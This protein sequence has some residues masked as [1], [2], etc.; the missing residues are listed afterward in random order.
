MKNFLLVCLTLAIQPLA[1]TMDPAAWIRANP[2]QV[3]LR[4]EDPFETNKAATLHANGVIRIRDT[5]GQVT[6]LPVDAKYYHITELM[7]YKDGSLMGVINGE[8]QKLP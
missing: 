1:N 8:L 3:L 2:D 7:F 6:V 4:S 5:Q